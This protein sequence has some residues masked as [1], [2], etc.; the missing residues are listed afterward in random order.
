ME[1][2]IISIDISPETTETQTENAGV[3]WEHNATSLVFNIHNTFV[4]DYRY[5]L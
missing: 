1:R 4:G 5:Y 2:K 3:M